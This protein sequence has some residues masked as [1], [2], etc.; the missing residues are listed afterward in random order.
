[1]RSGRAFKP[2]R[3]APMHQRVLLAVRDPDFARAGGDDRGA[4]AVPVGMVGDDQRQLDLALARARA[5][6][7]PAGRERGHRI[8]KAAR[9]HFL[10]GRRRTQRDGAGEL[11]LVGLARRPQLAQRDAA[12]HVVARQAFHRA[13]QIDRLVVAGLPDQRDHALRLAERIGADEMRALGKQRDRVQR[14]SR[15]SAIGSPWRNTGSPN[16][17]SV[18]NTSHRTSSNGAQVGSATSL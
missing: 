15:V 12:R 13:V 6:A 4:Q 1:M 7:H 11:G 2:L 17:A 8:G 10:H 3:L 9:P 18:M 5:H 16:V 14:A